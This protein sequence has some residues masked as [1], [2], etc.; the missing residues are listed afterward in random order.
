ME[1]SGAEEAVLRAARAKKE[2]SKMRIREEAIARTVGWTDYD[3]TEAAALIIAELNR[4]E[5]E[6]WSHGS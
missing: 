5:E 4:R 1:L 6:T 2:T 3:L